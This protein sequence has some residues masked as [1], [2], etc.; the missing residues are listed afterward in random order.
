MPHTVRLDFRAERNFL[1]QRVVV[2]YVGC[3]DFVLLAASRTSAAMIVQLRL[4]CMQTL[5]A[6]SVNFAAIFGL[7]LVGCVKWL[8]SFHGAIVWTSGR[9]V[10]NARRDFSYWAALGSRH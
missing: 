7:R 4:S 9:S 1:I 10:R 5:V 3:E 8:A 6:M 2:T